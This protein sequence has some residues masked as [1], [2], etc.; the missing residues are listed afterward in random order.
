MLQ[1]D[2]VLDTIVGRAIRDAE[3]RTKLLEAPIHAAEQAG[4][5]LTGSDKE[6]LARLDT[7]KAAS[8]FD[9]MNQKSTAMAWCSDLACY[10]TENNDPP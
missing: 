1:T 2:S 3:F 4:Y 6:L 9:K 8:F 7:D 5:T 10:E